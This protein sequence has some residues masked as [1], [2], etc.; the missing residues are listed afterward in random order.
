MVCMSDVRGIAEPPLRVQAHGRVGKCHQ[1]GHASELTGAADSEVGICSVADG[2]TCASCWRPVGPPAGLRV[3]SR[4]TMSPFA[5]GKGFGQRVGLG[6]RQ[7]RRCTCVLP[8]QPPE[9]LWFRRQR[10]KRDAGI[11]K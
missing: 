8:L 11:W 3:V 10:E 9:G 1:D 6:H 5:A 7:R 4:T 2:C